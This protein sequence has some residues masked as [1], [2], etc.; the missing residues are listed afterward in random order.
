MD[1][2][3]SRLDIELAAHSRASS[4]PSGGE[5]GRERQ[6][7]RHTSHEEHAISSSQTALQVTYP[8]TASR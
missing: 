1:V 7:E 4:D 6:R 3:L 2:E 8:V 5:P